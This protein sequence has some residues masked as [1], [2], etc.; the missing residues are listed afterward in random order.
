MAHIKCVRRASGFTGGY[1]YLATPWH[2]GKIELFEIFG[3]ISNGLEGDI[4][5]LVSLFSFVF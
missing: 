2:N 5:R 4:R 1:S 3:R